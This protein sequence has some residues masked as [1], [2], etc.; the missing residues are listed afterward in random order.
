MR[1]DHQASGGVKIVAPRTGLSLILGYMV[2]GIRIPRGTV[3]PC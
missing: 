3:D 2:Y 1:F